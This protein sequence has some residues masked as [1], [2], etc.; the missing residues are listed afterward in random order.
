M[1]LERGGSGA[2]SGGFGELVGDHCAGGRGHGEVGGVWRVRVLVVSCV[3]R[4]VGEGGEAGG[5][6]ECR[7]SS[8]RALWPFDTQSVS[9]GTFLFIP[10][11]ECGARWV[12]R[13]GSLLCLEIMP[14]E[15][16]IQSAF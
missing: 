8:Q 3:V 2:E 14:S 4:G 1:E 9:S 11:C 12:S 15:D 6:E 7:G 13:D 5:G 10:C 16:E